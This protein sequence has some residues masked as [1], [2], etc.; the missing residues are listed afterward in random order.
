M[1]LPKRCP[2]CG[3]STEISEVLTKLHCSNPRCPDKVAIRI[4][5][6]CDKLGILGFGE[7]TIDAFIDYHECVNPLN[8]FEFELGM[9]LGTDIS[10][11]AGDK[12]I[13]QILEKKNFQ[14]WEYVQIANIP[15][16]QT[17][18]KD[19]FGGYSSL[20]KAY[21]DIENGGVNFIQSKLGVSGDENGISVRA[22][23][24]Y[25]NLMEFKDDLFEDIDYVNIISYEGMKTINIYC[26]DQAGGGFKQKKDFYNYIETE[27][28]DK[29][30]FEI[31]GSINKKLNYLIWA[32]ADGTPC[33]VTSKVATVQKYQSQGY[34]I[35]I[36]TASQF[37]ERMREL[38]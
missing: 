26:S 13:S 33:R 18:A 35:P 30:H 2:S 22:I 7:S 34:D 14:L 29:I 25:T 31:V 23:Q 38:V 16:V 28:K 11:E 3:A 6:I 37:I 20:E 4:K 36:V 15:G 32:G 5:A 10:K 19:I 17:S 8:I 9:P 1:S 24:I 21:E 27:F 12:I